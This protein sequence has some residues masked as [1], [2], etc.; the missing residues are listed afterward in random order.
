MRGDFMKQGQK[1]GGR[2]IVFHAVALPVRPS[3]VVDFRRPALAERDVVIE[4]GDFP[5]ER[6]TTEIALRG[7]TQD[8]PK[9]RGRDVSAFMPS[10]VASQVVPS[11]VGSIGPI[12]AFAFLTFSHPFRQGSSIEPFVP[13]DPEFLERFCFFASGTC[14]FH[15]LNY[16]TSGQ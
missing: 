8:I 4:F 11:P 10:E 7:W 5:R 16:A 3:E 1:L 2:K 9:F 6:I 12:P 14:F 13:S 15:D